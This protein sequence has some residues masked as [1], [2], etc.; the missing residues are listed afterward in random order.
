MIRP[1]RKKKEDKSSNQSHARAFYGV[2]CHHEDTHAIGLGTMMWRERS[3]L[4]H[5]CI[6]KEIADCDACR[7]MIRFVPTKAQ[8]VT[9]NTALEG[10][11][12]DYFG[13]RYLFQCTACKVC[14]KRTNNL[15][16]LI[17]KRVGSMPKVVF[18][19]YSNV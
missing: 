1:S 15:I 12:D 3:D 10:D 8:R 14:F 5:H 7:E 13:R 16:F 2:G 4:K 6:R 11:A 9:K 17:H 19:F 18:H